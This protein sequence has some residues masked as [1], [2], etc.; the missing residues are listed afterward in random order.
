MTC[1]PSISVLDRVNK[2]CHKHNI[3]KKIPRNCQKNIVII[4]HETVIES[5]IHKKKQNP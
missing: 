4:I 5:L 3:F 1:L 2:T